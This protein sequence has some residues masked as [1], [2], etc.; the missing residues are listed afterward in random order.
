LQAGLTQKR[1]EAGLYTYDN[2]Y[3][4]ANGGSFDQTAPSGEAFKRQSFVTPQL[5]AGIVYF[6]SKQQSRLNPFLDTLCLI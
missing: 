6:N 1:I 3:S 4:S 5:N 2:Q